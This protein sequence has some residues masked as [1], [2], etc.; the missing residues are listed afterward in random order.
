MATDKGFFNYWVVANSGKGFITHTDSRK[1]WIRGYPG[2]VWVC[3]DIPESR[4]WGARNSATSKT[5]AEAQTIVT[6]IIDD[7]KDTWDNDN[8]DG[9]SA[10]DKLRRIGPKPTT[11]T[12][13]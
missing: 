1:F 6:D 10:S 7:A 13:P 3:D 8:V 11:I 12:L 4:D 5:K 9:E 2:N